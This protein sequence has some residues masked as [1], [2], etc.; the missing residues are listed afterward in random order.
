MN[1]ASTLPLEADIAY[2]LH[3]YDAPDGRPLDRAVMEE[4]NAVTVMSYRNR[5]R[6]PDGITTI[7]KQALKT[8]ARV[9]IPCRLAAETM[10]YG[11]T[12]TE[13]KQTFNSRNL[14]SMRRILR[15]VD[16]I[17]KGNPNYNGVAVHH[18]ASWRALSRR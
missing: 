5:A 14:R 3:S 10:Y 13:R 4:L 15:R 9:G 6:G 8:A 16:R 17:E 1:S 12:A 2:W 11:D 18:Y 7:G